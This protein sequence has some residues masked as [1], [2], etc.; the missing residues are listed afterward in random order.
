MNVLEQL[1]RSMHE[2]YIKLY[3][4]DNQFDSAID[5]LLDIHVYPGEEEKSVEVYKIMRL[6]YAFE[7]GSENIEEQRDARHQV[8][9]TLIK[10]F[11]KKKPEDYQKYLE[12]TKDILTLREY[13]DK[14]PDKA[15]ITKDFLMEVKS[16]LK[17]MPNPEDLN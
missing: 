12:E 5:T 14:N 9:D 11:K 13:L 6:L 4:E 10:V 15:L 2:Q 16:G 17:R 7:G 1:L 3:I 8:R